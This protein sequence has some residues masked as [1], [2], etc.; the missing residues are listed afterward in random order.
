M[1]RR[2]A[3]IKAIANKDIAEEG[4]QEMGAT[5]RAMAKVEGAAAKRNGVCF[6]DNPYRQGPPSPTD[7][8]YSSWEFGYIHANEL[9]PA[10]GSYRAGMISLMAASNRAMGMSEG[11]ALAE[12]EAAMCGAEA[13]RAH[14]PK[15]A[16]PYTNEADDRYS[17]A[18]HCGWVRGWESAETL[19]P[20]VSE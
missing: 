10:A 2:E 18:R 15:S 6:H 5:L 20:V 17:N 16:N 4:C 19:L 12:A 7:W 13:A 1:T 9:S 8:L 3:M 11:A 14:A